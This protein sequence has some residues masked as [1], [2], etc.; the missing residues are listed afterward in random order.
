MAFD[1]LGAVIAAIVLG[2]GDAPRLDPHPGGRF[3][4][5]TSAAV[6]EFTGSLG[7]RV[8]P[9]VG[10]RAEFNFS[11]SPDAAGLEI[12]FG[13][14]VLSARRAGKIEITSGDK[15]G[16]FGGDRVDLETFFALARWGVRL[17][18]RWAVHPFIGVG[19][20]DMT[21]QA[22]TATTRAHVTPMAGFGFEYELWRGEGLSGRMG[23]TLQLRGDVDW[24]RLGYGADGP[25]LAGESMGCHLGV[26][27]GLWTA[28][29]PPEEPIAPEFNPM[30][31]LFD[32]L[33]FGT[34]YRTFTGDLGRRLG[35]S[36]GVR[37]ALNVSV[38]GHL[39]GLDD[40]ETP[41][42]VD[43]AFLVPRARVALVDGVRADH[44][45]LPFISFYAG[46]RY[47]ISVAN[48]WS[49]H[50]MLGWATSGIAERRVDGS[51]PAFRGGIVA[52]MGTDW[53]FRRWA[54]LSL[55]LCTDLE[56][57]DVA[58]ERNGPSLGGDS[59]SAIIGLQMRFRPHPPAR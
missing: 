37:L 4:L 56:F 49:V 43:V 3:G 32:R 30:I 7:E 52:G 47:H 38:L 41:L 50:P 55:A 51:S 31:Y 18:P 29:R 21:G 17:G 26:R 58:L 25:G 24:M 8:G 13:A 15:T 28:P 27:L 42:G 2:A 22:G 33:E 16:A 12:G 54:G 19:V 1:P 53:E 36:P 48:R 45:S 39:L 34:S 14:E 59:F 46:A 9:A 11:F 6:R 23:P 57:Q 5:H 10:G 20:G 44:P 40:L 35:P